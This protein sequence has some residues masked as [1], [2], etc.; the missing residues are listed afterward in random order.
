MDRR[1]PA[2]IVITGKV[3]GK[4]IVA[5]VCYAYGRSFSTQNIVEHVGRSIERLGPPVGLR[6][7]K[8]YDSIALF[9]LGLCW[10]N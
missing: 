8:V 7:G 1:F 5:E 9:S 4:E 3:Y 6:I 2:T 10:T